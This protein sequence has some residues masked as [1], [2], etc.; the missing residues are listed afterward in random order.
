MDCSLTVSDAL[1]VAAVT[2]RGPAA[3]VGGAFEHLI[4]WAEV[5]HVEQWGPLIAVY[6]DAPEGAV[7]VRCQA[8]LPIPPGEADRDPG[9]PRIRIERIE[10]RTM[11]ACVHRGFP[12]EVGRAVE[13]L[14]LWI[15]DRGLVRSAPLHRQIY[16]EAPPGE[17]AEWVVE[18]QVPVDG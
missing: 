2:Y 8:W 18:V 1:V 15:G 5:E 11:A 7:E 10:P 17:P 16:H 12:D 4:R 13:R 9:D 14:A 3:G 6:D